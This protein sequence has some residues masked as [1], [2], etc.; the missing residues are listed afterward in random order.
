[1]NVLCAGVRCRFMFLLAPI[2]C[3]YTLGYEPDIHTTVSSVAQVRGHSAVLPTK[4]LKS[5]EHYANRVCAI[6]L[7]DNPQS[8]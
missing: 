1:M 6:L 4:R 8:D 5:W 3:D 7:Q 2:V